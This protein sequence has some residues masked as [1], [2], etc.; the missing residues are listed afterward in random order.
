GV[1]AWTAWI[2]AAEII[3]ENLAE[4][5]IAVT[6]KTLDY[7]SW[8]DAL[9]RGKFELS[10]GF[11]SRGP[12]PYDFARGQLDA[13]PVLKVGERTDVNFHRFGD[14]EATRLLRRLEQT[15]QAGE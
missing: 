6:T 12:T 10:L 14:T 2:A 1:R 8:D 9:R 15:S 7:N 13:T 4:V 3:R 5:G 11:G